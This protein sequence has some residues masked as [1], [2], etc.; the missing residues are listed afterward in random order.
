MGLAGLPR[1][2]GLSLMRKLLARLIENSVGASAAEYAILLAI[3]GAAIA[4][5][6]VA[7]G[8]SISDAMNDA[9]SNIAQ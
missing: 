9:T 4:L 3:I 2:A 1:R 7:L 8:I 5:G 6:S